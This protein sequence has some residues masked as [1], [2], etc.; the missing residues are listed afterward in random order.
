MEAVKNWK[1]KLTARDE[2]PKFHFPGRFTL[3]TTT[4]Y[5]REISLY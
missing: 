2:N 3:S 4:C 1:V 5:S